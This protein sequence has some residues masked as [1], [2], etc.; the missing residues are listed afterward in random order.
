MQRFEN[1]TVIVTG[2][3]SGIGEATARR[4]HAE[5]A[6]VVLVG[7]TREKLEKVAQGLSASERVLVHPGDVASPSDV[8]AVVSATIK[9]FGGI[10][11]LVNNAGTAVT[12]PFADL[13]FEDWRQVMSIDIDGIFHMTKAAL[14]HLLRAMGSVVNVSSVSGIGGDWH[15]S[16]YNAAKGAVTNLTRSLALELGGQGVRVNAVNP[17]LT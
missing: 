11:V 17:S 15:M 1:K 4:F 7:R 5:G 3:G 13:S 16:A 2:A 6:R 10:D 14:P 8:D 12:G 9:R